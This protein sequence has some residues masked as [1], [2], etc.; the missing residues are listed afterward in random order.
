MRYKILHILYKGSN[1]VEIPVQKFIPVKNSVKTGVVYVFPHLFQ[2][3]PNVLK[4]Y[5]SSKFAKKIRKFH[6]G[7]ISRNFPQ[8]IARG[9]FVK[10]NY[11]I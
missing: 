9:S 11:F 3:Y 7:D 10:R 1:K 6:Q 2:E 4:S 8:V 5:L